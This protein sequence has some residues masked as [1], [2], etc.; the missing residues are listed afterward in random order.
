MGSVGLVQWALERSVGPRLNLFPVRDRVQ[1]VPVPS[2][3]PR[4]R[5]SDH[6]PSSWD[7]SWRDLGVRGVLKTTAN[8]TQKGTPPQSSFL[9]LQSFAMVRELFDLLRE[10]L[11]VSESLAARLWRGMWP[12]AVEPNL[13]EMIRV[14]LP[15]RSAGDI[16]RCPPSSASM[17]SDTVRALPQRVRRSA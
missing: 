4:L 7:P 15:V 17:S 13:S 11:M 1:L 6:T 3:R 8:T 12:Q 14:R 2:E 16:F 9:S 10:L 5:R